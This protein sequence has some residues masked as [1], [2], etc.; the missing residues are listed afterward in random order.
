MRTERRT[1]NKL[2]EKNVRG[3]ANTTKK[4][5]EDTLAEAADDVG[6]M[7]GSKEKAGQFID[8]TVEVIAKSK[9]SQDRQRRPDL[10]IEDKPIHRKSFL[11]SNNPLAKKK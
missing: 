4:N 3:F 2:E 7:T 1:R 9:L 5:F 10:R 11:F 6:R 8:D